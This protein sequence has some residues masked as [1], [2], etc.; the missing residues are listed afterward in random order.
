MRFELP[1]Y[2]VNYRDDE[3]HNTPA[4]KK[5]EELNRFLRENWIEWWIACLDE[6]WQVVKRYTNRVVLDIDDSTPSEKL[7]KIKRMVTELLRVMWATETQLADVFGNK[8]TEKVR[9]LNK[10]GN[11]EKEKFNSM[12]NK[13]NFLIKTM[14]IIRENS[15]KADA[16][17]I[18]VTRDFSFFDTYRDCWFRHTGK[19]I[20]FND[21]S[22]R[23][24]S[25]SYKLQSAIE[26]GVKS[27][28]TVV[29]HM[30]DY[31]K[32]YFD[33]M[34]LSL[35]R[36]VEHMNMIEEYSKKADD[37]WVFVKKDFTFDEIYRNWWFQSSHWSVDLYNLSEKLRRYSYKLQEEVTKKE[38]NK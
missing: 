12:R 20:N 30:S 13:L 10:M 37:L 7:E 32:E 4:G 16:L 21:L 25:H 35:V 33:A 9:K 1:W 23:F 5:I 26:K 34:K 6:K 38:K 31:E 22:D 24:L 28:R 2:D 19:K 17:W 11:Y 27:G 8:G 29:E 36:I 14:D 15:S 18:L 3:H